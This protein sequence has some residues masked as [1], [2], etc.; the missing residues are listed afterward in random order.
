MIAPL[1]GYL[2]GQAVAR[3]RDIDGP[4]SLPARLIG[5]A[6]TVAIVALGLNYAV[7]RNQ[8]F[9]RSWP[10][11]SGTVAYLREAGIQPGEPVLAAGSQVYEYYLDLGAAHRDMWSNTWYLRY[12]GHEGLDAMRRA[13]ADRYFTWVILD[14]YYTPEID[15]ALE[16]D[17]LSAGYRLVYSDPQH[18]STG[19]DADLR[20]Y[21]RP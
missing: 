2:C 11:V 6:G 19:I 8:G 16:P 20:V 1:A 21:Q 4:W 10:D 14:S 12:D 9:Q 18:L 7:A 5:L 13:A 17:L 3:V 15:R